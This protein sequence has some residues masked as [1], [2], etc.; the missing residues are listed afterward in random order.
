MKT[1]VVIPARLESKRFPGKLLTPIGGKPLIQQVWEK[2]RECRL[3]DQVIVATDSEQIRNV[4]RSFGGMT[5]V[6]KGDFRSGTDRIA[7]LTDRLPSK[8]YVNLQGDEWIQTPRVLDDL[9][10][11]FWDSQPLAMGTLIQKITEL[12]ELTDPNVVKVVFNPEGFAIYFSRASIPFDRDKDPANA[13]NQGSSY[14]HLGIYIYLKE[15]LEKIA[16]FP[17]TPLETIEKLEQ[18]R[19]LENGIA[20]KTWETGFKSLRIDTPE[21]AESAGKSLTMM[22]P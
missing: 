20:I 16:G 18:L 8:A 19:A 17:S 11:K 22:E 2:A 21:D 4:V 1:V 6:A 14:K 5:I 15:T 9:I 12:S 7:S 10:E 3:A 13:N